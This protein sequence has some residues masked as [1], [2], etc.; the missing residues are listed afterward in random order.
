MDPESDSVRLVDY[1]DGRPSPRKRRSGAA[2]RTGDSLEMVSDSEL[3][4]NHNGM[5]E[6]TTV[7]SDTCDENLPSVRAHLAASRQYRESKLAPPSS[8][9]Y[10]ETTP[11]LDDG[12]ILKKEVDPESSGGLKEGSMNNDGY[13]KLDGSGNRKKSKWDVV[14]KWYV[15]QQWCAVHCYL[16]DPHVPLLG[17][18][19]SKWLS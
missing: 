11:L 4:K 8:R 13:E 17:T 19:F 1:R 3:D 7:F 5:F 16:S 15:L 12:S 6:D 10:K 9:S 2:R 14:K 18:L